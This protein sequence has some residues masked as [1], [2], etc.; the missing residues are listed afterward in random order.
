[1]T[2]SL[3]HTRF[4][5][6]A[7]GSAW[8]NATRTKTLRVGG[9]LFTSREDY[10]SWLYD[11]QRLDRRLQILLQW[12]LPQLVRAAEQHDVRHVIS[13]STTLPEKYKEKLRLA[14]DTYDLLILHETDKVVDAYLPPHNVV[15][16]L[17]E[18]RGLAA[19][20]AFAAYRLDDDD[21]L[22]ADYFDQMA[23]YVTASNVGFRVSLGLGISCIWRNGRLYA[24]RET[25]YPKIS[26]GMVSVC[27][28]GPEGQ[29][30]VPERY[31]DVSEDNHDFADRGA[32]VIT[33]CRAVAYLRILHDTQSGVLHRIKSLQRHWYM[34]AMMRIH[35]APPVQ[36][37]V[38]QKKF[39][40]LAEVIS[41]AHGGPEETQEL[42]GEELVLGEERIPFRVR[43]DDPFVIEVEFDSDEAANE[44]DVAVKWQLE[45]D[46]NF[47]VDSEE[48][49]DHLT[50][51]D[52]RYH[53][54]HGYSTWLPTHRRYGS[55]RQAMVNL[56]PKTAVTGLIV[57]SRGQ[58]P[59]R[60]RQIRLTSLPG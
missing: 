2:F 28:L 3:G 11:E 34:D 51:S 42:L 23:P 36:E 41:A 60:I 53:R 31:V 16:G 20:E 24:A 13:Y 46:D 57:L 15:T 30:I 50:H 37:S 22:S 59:T 33:D 10:L 9:A 29:L 54:R 25:Y 8:F 35:N 48:C 4:S 5:I 32:P 56:H 26:M 14:A 18:K 1:M 43:L 44:Q 39:P 49:V 38:V 12:S 40:G 58:R 52:V 55:T 45:G 17:L 19:N 7:Y 47:E 6:D 21:V 27:A